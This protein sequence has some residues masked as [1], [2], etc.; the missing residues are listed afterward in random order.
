VIDAAGPLAGE[1]VGLA[2]ALD[3]ARAVYLPIEGG[4]AFEE[5]AARLEPL[6][7][8]GGSLAWSGCDSKQIQMLFGERGF[9]FAV[10][11]FDAEIA[12][13]LL[14]STAARALPALAAQTLGAKLRS[15]E[16]C[17]RSCR[18]STGASWNGSNARSTGWRARSS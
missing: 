18:A 15:W 7:G 9:E 5:V 12:G 4:L 17:S 8:A 16:E 2:L 13:Q 14:D 10:P 6:L 3:A 1:A 11:R